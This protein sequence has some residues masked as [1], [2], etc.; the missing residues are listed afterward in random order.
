MNY[1][2]S[3]INDDEIVV[4]DTRAQDFGNSFL[5]ATDAKLQALKFGVCLW[6]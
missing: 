4:D 2:F 5:S 1:Y 6:F 3:K